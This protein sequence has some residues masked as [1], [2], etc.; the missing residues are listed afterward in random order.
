ML[1]AAA[2]LAASPTVIQG[3]ERIGRFAV[4]RDGSL[5]GLVDAFGRAS[6]LRRTGQAGCIARWR[7]LRM[8]VRLYNLGGQ[9]PCSR[10]GGRFGRAFLAG[11]QFR[12]SKGLRVRDPVARVR[13][14]Y[15]RA[16]RHGA[17]YWLVT[18]RSRFGLGGRY[19]GLAAKVVRGRVV[20]FRVEYPAGGD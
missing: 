2:A 17:W 5:G 13:A 11:P 19:A 8:E 4:K 1:L 14:L 20:T 18:R 12:T 15:P 16:T 7:P 9:D 6:S 3:D 10:E